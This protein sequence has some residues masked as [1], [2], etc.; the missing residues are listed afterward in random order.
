MFYLCVWLCTM[1][2]EFLWE[3]AEGIRSPGTKVTDGCELPCDAHAVL[4]IKPG[5]S[6]LA[7]MNLTVLH[8]SS[9]LYC[10]IWM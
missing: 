6:A 7:V 5:A 4:G 1:C 3:P 8:L 10:I 9:L 2:V